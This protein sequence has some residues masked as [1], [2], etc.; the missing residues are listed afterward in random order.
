MNGLAQMLPFVAIAAFAVLSIVSSLLGAL[1]AMARL[2]AET[3]REGNL[4]T[5][6]YR[7]S[8]TVGRWDD[9]TVVAFPVR[10]KVRLHHPHAPRAAA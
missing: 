1:P 4:R 9:G 7:I 8:E 6:T 3:A 2:R 10:P 5:Y